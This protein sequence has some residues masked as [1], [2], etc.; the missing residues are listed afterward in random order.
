MGTTPTVAGAARPG[1]LGWQCVEVLVIAHEAGSGFSLDDVRDV[2]F[3]T[4]AQGRWTYL[5]AAWT[6]VTGFAVDDSLGRVFLEYIHPDDRQRNLDL[7]EPL[8]QRLKGHCFHEIR[9][10]TRDGGFKWIEVHARLTVD[11]DGSITGT[12]GTLRDVTARREA[13]L[14]Q[15]RLRETLEESEA[16]FREMANGAPVILWMSNAKGE[17]Q[18]VNRKYEEFFGVRPEQVYGHKWT[19]YIHPEDAPAYLSEV[20]AAVHG[21]SAFQAEVRVRRH[22]G[23]W[24]WVSNHGQPRFSASGEF[25]GHAGIALDITDRKAI[26]SALRDNEAKLRVALAAAR[27]A[28]WEYDVEGDVWALGRE[29]EEITRTPREQTT[30]QHVQA[31]HPE[32]RPRAQTALRRAI[33]IGGDRIDVEFRVQS[34]HGGEPRWLRMIGRATDRDEGGR[35][36]RLS[37]VVMDVT[38]LHSLQE[39]LIAATRLASVGTLAAGVA[40]EINNPL[41]WV[42]TNLRYALEGLSAGPSDESGRAPDLAEVRS[43]L[44]EAHQGVGRIADIVKAMRSLGR[45]DQSAQPS[46]VDVR[47][48]ILSAAQMARSQVLQRAQLDIDVPADLPPVSAKTSELGRVF[49]NL[50]LNA[51]QAIPKGSE[52]GNRVAVRAC[53]Q[54]AAVVV[55]VSD[56]GTGIEPSIRD[57]IFDPFFTTKPPGVGTGLGL[58]IVRSIVSAAG[59]RIEFDSTPNRGSTFRVV[60]PVSGQ[61]ASEPRPG[62]ARLDPTEPGERR[63]VLVVDDEPLVGRSIQRL[64]GRKHEV[65]VLTSAN[66]ALRLIEHG[67]RWD[68]VLCDFTM[69]DLDGIALYE[70]VAARVPDLARRWAFI[71]GGAV[72]E[73]TTAFLEGQTVPTLDKPVEPSAAFELI[74]RLTTE[75]SARS[76]G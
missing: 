50:L 57:R 65:T 2:V 15:Q 26:E 24:R 55:E 25:L 42:K 1:I 69:P 31:I 3:H 64:L 45:P 59:G 75:C 18:F 17:N 66:E 72:S 7:F 28:E 52:A 27:Q 36:R 23:A 61:E 74:N 70:A 19:P 40:H 76:V 33:E 60:L 67:Q 21:R 51:A 9:Y 63:R 47:S 73:R 10:L 5:N 22:D 54:G 6:E 4:D 48:E 16:R 12:T 11:A 43:A 13:E 14:S 39:S 53:K 38:E 29:W 41:S 8:I 49:L 35:A 62:P 44:D 20:I 56:S 68:A 46:E 32:D 30:E 71:T 58:S 37:G 34:G